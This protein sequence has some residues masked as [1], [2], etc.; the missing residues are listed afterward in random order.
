[1]S[2]GFKGRAIDRT[3][4]VHVDTGLVAVTTKQIYFLVQKA[5][6]SLNTKIGHSSHL[7]MAW[8]S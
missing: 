8:E 4:R 6:E 5:F 7:A 3:E 2:A 1:M